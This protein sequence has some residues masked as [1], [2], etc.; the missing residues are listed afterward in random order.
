MKIES[1]GSTLLI[2]LSK[3]LFDDTSQMLDETLN[4]YCLIL[5]YPFRYLSSSKSNRAGHSRA[6]LTHSLKCDNRG[7]AHFL[8]KFQV[9]AQ[10]NPNFLID[11]Q[12]FCV[13]CGR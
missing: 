8:L 3:L 12:L 2:N 13:I 11:C 7:A 6:V 5:F 9:K 4:V 10:T 1:G